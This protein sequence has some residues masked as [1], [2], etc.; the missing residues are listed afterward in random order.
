MQVVY[1][2]SLH[3]YDW[4]EGWI[5]EFVRCSEREKAITFYDPTRLAQEVQ[6]GLAGVAYRCLD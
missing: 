5:E 4:A 3:D 2:A 6:S 1:R